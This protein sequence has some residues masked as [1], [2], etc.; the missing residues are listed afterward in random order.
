[1]YANMFIYTST[2]KHK[3]THTHKKRRRNMM[4]EEEEVK[5]RERRKPTSSIRLVSVSARSFP[6]GRITLNMGGSLCWAGGPDWVKDRK[7]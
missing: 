3:G 6:A 2:H 7:E 1:M 5:R 4:G